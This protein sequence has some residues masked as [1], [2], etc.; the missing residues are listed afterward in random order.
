MA[1]RLQPGDGV[2]ERL[3]QPRHLRDAAAGQHDQQRL[4]RSEPEARGQRRRIE[5]LDPVEP[6]DHRMT[7]IGAGRAAETP[8]H[9]RLERQ[10]RHHVIDVAAHA[11]GA[12]P[13]RHAHTLGLT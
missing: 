12:R 8:M 13:G 5:R 4:A 10:Q 6:L 3:H 2:A 9:R 7:R 1:H 11:L